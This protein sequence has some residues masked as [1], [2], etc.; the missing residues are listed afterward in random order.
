MYIGLH[1]KRVL[2][3]PD[4]KKNQYV[5]KKSDENFKY[6]SSQTPAWWELL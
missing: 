4:F 5:Y 3:L 6:Q 1:V 2:F